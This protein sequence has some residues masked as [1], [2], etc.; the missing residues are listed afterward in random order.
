MKTIM[1]SY[2]VLT[3][4]RSV[5]H[6]HVNGDI[7]TAGI[8]SDRIKER[9]F[10]QMMNCIKSTRQIIIVQKPNLLLGLSLFQD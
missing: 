1:M 10:K 2:P 4:L 6:P 5:D 7:P 9:K 8:A 3:S